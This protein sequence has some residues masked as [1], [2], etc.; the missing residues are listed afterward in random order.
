MEKFTYQDLKNLIDTLSPEQLLKE[1]IC[2]GEETMGGRVEK[3]WIVEEDH[4]NPSGEYM[5]PI[6]S[7]K[8]DPDIDL[9]MEAIVCAKGTP[10]LVLTK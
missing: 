1:V 7:Y 4:I 10:I 6:S 2:C 9:E 8:D 3:L 5:E